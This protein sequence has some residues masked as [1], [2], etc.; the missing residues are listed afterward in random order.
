[1]N[2]NYNLPDKNHFKKGGLFYKVKLRYNSKS[3]PL[4]LM[5]YI[6]PDYNGIIFKQKPAITK[7]TLRKVM[8]YCIATQKLAV[9]EDRQKNEAD[10]KMIETKELEDKIRIYFSNYYQNLYKN[11]TCGIKINQ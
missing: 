3:L 2:S 1:M 6:F 5:T 7:K 4:E 9:K 10:R 11:C 8:D